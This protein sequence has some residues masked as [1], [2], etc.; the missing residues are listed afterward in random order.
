MI[1]PQ[2]IPLTSLVIALYRSR[3]SRQT[4]S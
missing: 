1:W 4:P 3:R 2:Y